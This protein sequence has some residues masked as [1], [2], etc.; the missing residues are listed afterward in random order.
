MNEPKKPLGRP[1]IGAIR[2]GISLVPLDRAK[3]L[4]IGSGSL[5]KGVRKALRSYKLKENIDGQ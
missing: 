2:V 4:K 5:S 1:F 3:A